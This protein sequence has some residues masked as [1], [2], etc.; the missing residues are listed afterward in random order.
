MENSREKLKGERDIT[1]ANENA[2]LDVYAILNAILSI[3][4]ILFKEIDYTRG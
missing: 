1:S 2:I 4:L 3:M